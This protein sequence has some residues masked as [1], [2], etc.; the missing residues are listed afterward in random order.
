MIRIFLPHILDKKHDKPP[1]KPLKLPV[2]K[3]IQ[4]MERKP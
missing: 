4:H 1:V 2:I 3:H